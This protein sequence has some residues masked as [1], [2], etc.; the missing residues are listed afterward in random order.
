MIAQVF[1]IIVLAV[2]YK[3]FTTT[4]RFLLVGGL[5]SNQD[6]NEFVNLENA[7]SGPC[8]YDSS[9]LN[10]VKLNGKMTGGVSDHGQT[11]IACGGYD[12]A[13]C[14]VFTRNETLTHQLSNIRY[15]ASSVFLKSGLLYVTGGVI[16]KDAEYVILV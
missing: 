15:K 13:E 5:T 3:L 6:Q 14:L 10:E 4:E 8:S 12:I 11:I 2:F 1:I 7:L 16:D 9:I